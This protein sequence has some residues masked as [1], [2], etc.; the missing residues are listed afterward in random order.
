MKVALVCIAKEE[1]KY[2]QEWIDYH[3]K[4]GFDSIFIYQNDWR[5]SIEDSCVT[6]IEFDGVNM[7][8][9]A[10]NDFIKNNYKKYDWAAF[11]DVDE[12]LV[13]KKHKT[14]K[15]FI[16]DYQ[17]MSCIG[18][19][20]V[21]FGNNNLTTV[22]EDLSVLSRFIRRQNSVNKHIKSIIKLSKNITMDVH[23]PINS[24]ISDT[25]KNLFIGPF[26]DKGDDNIAQ[27]NH[28]FCKTQEEFAE[29]S[30]RGRADTPF[31][32]QHRRTIKDFEN[33]NFNEVEDQS[34]LNFF[35]DNNYIFNP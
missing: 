3:K 7:Q 20:W 6:K 32:E 2:I 16:S 21:L 31:V 24:V 34:A 26:N 11:F 13:L 33:H 18:I 30:K 4:L 19:N 10:Y 35:Y 25:N 22:D 17:G 28:Y 12:F 14:I 15:E 8:T 29:K 23:C 27:L 5:C 9:R 1:D